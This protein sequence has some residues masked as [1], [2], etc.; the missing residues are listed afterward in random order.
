M[1]F[2]KILIMKKLLLF[3]LLSISLTLYSCFTSFR[4]TDVDYKGRLGKPYQQDTIYLPKTATHAIA[5]LV[6]AALVT[7]GAGLLS[8]A[9]GG[10]FG[11][12]SSK[13]AASVAH[14]TNVYNKQIADAYNRSQ[15]TIAQ[16]ANIANRNLQ[17][18]QNEFNKA[19]WDAEN[20]YNTPV[21]Q[22]LRYAAAGINPYFALGN[23]SAGNAQSAV[24]QNGYTPTVTPNQQLYQQDPSAMV[25][26]VQTDAQ[27]RIAS[28]NQA[29]QAAVSAYDIFN[30]SQKLPGELKKMASDTAANL[31]HAGLSGSQKVMQDM[32]N[33]SYKKDLELQDKSLSD[34][35]TS[36][37]YNNMSITV[38]DPDDESNSASKN[39]AFAN[40]LRKPFKADI[41]TPRLLKLFNS[42]GVD[43]AQR[44]EAFRRVEQISENIEAIR[45]GINESKSRENLNNEQ[46]KVIPRQIAVAERQ[47]T[48]AY[49]NAQTNRQNANTMEYDAKTRRMHLAIDKVVASAMSA[50]ARA[51]A[52]LLNSKAGAQEFNNRVIN[53]VKA[54]LKTMAQLNPKEYTDLEGYFL[55]HYVIQNKQGWQTID[56]NTP[57]GRYAL[58]FMSSFGSA[59]GDMLGNPLQIIPGSAW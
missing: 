16:Q 34:A 48:I 38:G 51:N 49:I 50:Q 55:E 26:A 33:E 24:Q 42:L 46:A 6:G 40:F 35:F 21:Q 29:I 13:K 18:E 4:G 58:E 10:I 53:E 30:R 17:N 2:K 9:I 23:I 54:R 37:I 20:A 8:S 28:F 14:E 12:S 47:A 15:E 36:A 11:H 44:Q 32:Q 45:Q 56:N 39:E 19:M 43:T 22:R 1:L 41:M 31:A 27:T 3:L 52:R 5:P 25:Q 59:Q 7:G 57:I